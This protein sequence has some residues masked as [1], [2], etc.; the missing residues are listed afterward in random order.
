VLIA[1]LMTLTLHCDV[2]FLSVLETLNG[3]WEVC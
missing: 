1:V 2:L 3:E